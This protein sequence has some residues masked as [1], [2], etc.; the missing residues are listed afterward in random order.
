MI[1][2]KDSDLIEEPRVYETGNR[3]RLRKLIYWKVYTKI[4][5]LT[6][7]SAV[8]TKQ[9]IGTADNKIESI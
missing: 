7:Q 4:H 5:T 3:S 2:L 1:T 9:V 6:D 8:V